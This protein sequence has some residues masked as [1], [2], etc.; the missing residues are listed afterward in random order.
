MT[1][2]GEPLTGP[3]HPRAADV[4]ADDLARQMA[5]LTARLPAPPAA[6]LDAGCGTGDLAAAL[7]ERGYDVTAVD[8]DP[9]AVAAAQN[10][11]VSAVRAD[12][13]EFDAGPFDVVVIS[14]SLH[15]VDRLEAA[16]TRVRR[17]LRPTGLLVVDEFAWDAADRPTAAWF[18]DAAA[19]LDGAGLWRGTNHRKPAADPL[20]RWVRHHRDEHR[21]HS[22]DAMLRAI[23]AAFDI[24]EES[25]IPYLHR[26]LGGWLAADAN[27]RTAFTSLREQETVHV[28]RGR[29]RP[30]GLRVIAHPDPDHT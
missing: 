28:N 22:G 6:V 17:L 25:R 8:I 12:I 1:T 21:M 4:A 14:L 5:F 10:A 2:T 18:Y 15:H 29:L 13:A 24:R 16:V 11:G 26:Y 30:V 23:A 20:D 3:P 9:A 19:L 7:C 27:A